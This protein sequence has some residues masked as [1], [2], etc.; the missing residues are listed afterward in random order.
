VPDPAWGGP[1]KAKDINNARIKRIPV[2]FIIPVNC[3]ISKTNLSSQSLSA[4][5][6]PNTEQRNTKKNYR[7]AQR[8]AH[9]N[10]MRLNKPHKTVVQTGRTFKP[11]PSCTV[12][13]K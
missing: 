6:Q 2:E 10:T 11:N 12:N 4:I 1:F 7:K 9:E 5:Q 3:V 13:Q 8:E